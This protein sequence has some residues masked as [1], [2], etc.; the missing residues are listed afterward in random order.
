MCVMI[1]TTTNRFRQ[2]EGHSRRRSLLLLLLDLLLASLV[3]T[4]AARRNEADLHPRRS[5]AADGGGVP[6][7]LVVA[8]AVRVLDRVHRH[9]ADLAERGEVRSKFS[10]GGRMHDSSSRETQNL[11]S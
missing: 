11:V 2:S 8:S 7:V 4:G 5:A 6:D 10:A 1:E 3:Q 9:T